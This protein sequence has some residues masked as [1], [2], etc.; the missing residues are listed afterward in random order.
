MY[1]IDMLA[2]S[3]Q[4]IEVFLFFSI[5]HVQISLWSM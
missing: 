5:M 2:L 1:H 4:F 3:T